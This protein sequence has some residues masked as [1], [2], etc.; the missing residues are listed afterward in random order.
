MGC[1]STAASARPPA[2]PSV[3][4]PRPCWPPCRGGTRSPSAA[5]RTSTRSLRRRAAH[6]QGHPA[7]RP[8][9]QQPPLG[10]RRPDD[11][12]SRLRGQP[13]DPQA[14]RGGVRL[15]Q[16]NCSAA[17]HPTLRQAARRL[18]IHPGGCGLQP[19]PPA[20]AAGRGMMAKVT[21]YPRRRSN[22]SARHRQAPCTAAPDGRQER[23]VPTSAA[24]SAAC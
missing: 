16:G 24:I 13:A 7:R 2:A 21:S 1:S 9:H 8:E 11:A 19:D 14:D 10:H 5:T 6:A 15:D 17:A 4:W 3:M 22:R 12:P 20:Q 23:P 18:A